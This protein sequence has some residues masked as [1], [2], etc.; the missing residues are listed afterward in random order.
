VRRF[1]QRLARILEVVLVLGIVGIL[2]GVAIWLGPG[3][4]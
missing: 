1:F 3:S 2:V 4:P